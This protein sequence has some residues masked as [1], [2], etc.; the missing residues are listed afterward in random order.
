MIAANKWANG[1][2]HLLLQRLMELGAA[3]EEAVDWESILDHR[4]GDHCAG[5]WKEMTK[6]LGRS[7]HVS[8]EDKLELLAKRYAPGLV[9]IE[10][11]I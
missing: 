3:S 9:G 7:D 11:E 2:D 4:E 5:R 1:D 6:P 10:E 8:F